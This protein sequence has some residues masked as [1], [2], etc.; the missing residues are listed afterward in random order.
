MKVKLPSI[1]MVFVALALVL[2]SVAIAPIAVS[3]DPGANS[4]SRMALPS[5][6]NYQM[7]P[8]SDIWDITAADDGTVFAIVQDTSGAR[9]TPKWSNFAVF[10]STDGGY[11]W[12]LM[13]HIPTNEPTVFGAIGVPVEIVPQPNYDDTD[14]ANQVVFLATDDNLYRSINGGQAF[15]RINPEC[16]GVVDP[17]TAIPNDFISS[18]DV[19]ENINNPG[20]YLAVVGIS[21]YG[22]GLTWGE[23]V[24]TWNEDNLLSW[25]DKRVGNVPYG[26]GYEALDVMFSPNYTDDGVIIA[27]LNDFAVN[28]DV[29]MSFYV[30]SDGLWNGPTLIDGIF[31]IGTV[32]SPVPGL[33]AA[34]TDVAD[35][36]HYTSNPWVFA[37][38]NDWTVAGGEVYAVKALPLLT[39]PSSL[40]L[41]RNAAAYA[42]FSDI[43]FTGTT[44]AGTCYVS[45]Q[46][47]NN[48]IEGK[49][50]TL[51]PGWTPS[52][53]SPTGS[54]PI[55]LADTGDV[56][57]AATYTEIAVCN[58]ALPMATSSGISKQ[59]VASTGSVYNGIGLLDDLAVTTDV[60]GV[61]WYVT[62]AYLETS[63]NYANDDTVFVATSSEWYQAI[64]PC[65]YTLSL[66]RQAP[67]G[68]NGAVVWERLLQEGT[69]RFTLVPTGKLATANPGIFTGAPTALPLPTLTWVPK[70]DPAFAN[71]NFMFLL[72]GIGALNGVAGV[73]MIWYSPDRGDTWHPVS[74]M[75]PMATP[76][77]LSEIGWCVVD[78]STI[79][80][81]DINGWVYKTTDRGNSWS[82]G[83]FTDA[84]IVTDLNVSPAYSTDEAVIAGVV[85][86]G[87]LTP[88]NE[89]WIS[90]DGAESDFTIV[91]DELMWEPWYGGTLDGILG[92]MANFDADWENNGL[93]YGAASGAMDN[94]VLNPISGVAELQDTSEVGIYRAEVNLVDTQASTWV[95][96]YGADD[97]IAESATPVDD[98][99]RYVYLTD[100]SIGA[101]GTIYVP[102]ALYHD[103][104]M[105]TITPWSIMRYTLGG[106]VRCLD[107]TA[108][109]ADL[110]KVSGVLGPFDG[111]WLMSVVPG[112]NHLFSAAW[113]VVDWRFKLAHYEDTLS[114]AGPAAGAD[115]PAD[116]ATAVGAIAGNTV[117]VPLSWAD[118]GA[119]T[120]ELQVSKD[121]AF[122]SPTT[123][124]TS[125]TSATASGL[126]QGVTYYWRVRALEPVLG[127]WSAARSFTT[128]TAG[129]LIGPELVSPVA[130]A[131]GVPTD[132]SFVWTK[133]SWAT[134][135]DL[136]VRTATATIVSVTDYTGE[137][138]Q[139]TTQLDADTTYFWSVTAKSADNEVSSGDSSFSTAAAIG[140]AEPTPAWVW[141]VIAI[142]AILLIAVIVLIIRTRRPA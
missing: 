63:P 54:W 1:V 90:L 113:D 96:L 76:T 121:S 81:G 97:F 95:P 8:D 40:V 45:S 110:I 13:W 138:Y 142:S 78:N 86:Q 16:P 26:L 2:S 82:N 75:P 61:I 6:N 73:D 103:D 43:M 140:A 24:F 10:K 125:D 32:P 99:V 74:Q 64:N 12:S 129:G 18:L 58:P 11:T 108:A 65:G 4:F 37:F 17:D 21:S 83:A 101:D 104:S 111:L 14:T 139:P 118:T 59:I 100:L 136:V 39:G 72:A 135:Y 130:N 25:R 109:T 137:A 120:Y 131:R 122:T 62:M 5:V 22:V 69:P 106:M 15:T 79:L 44:G 28:N 117:N 80:A 98:C 42:R 84:G 87:G 116:G 48:V 30:S 60:N 105:G 50:L 49:S 115:A 55:W 92:C 93:V 77:D 46:S 20:T 66:W 34:G 56:A 89:V 91:G 124:T 47:F 53:K 133:V 52:I 102:F 3:A 57:L 71:T 35:D 114:G 107:G 127:N 123:I 9:W 67:T 7:F 23:G 141:V 85:Y 134:G 70:V 41:V 31:G 51:W 119:T 36:F 88:I 29:I 132:T 112:S 128:I 68:P 94:W 38:V 19:A 27:I 126:E 33:P